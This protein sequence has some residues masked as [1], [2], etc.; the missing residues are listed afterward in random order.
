MFVIG[1]N[2]HRTV[3]SLSLDNWRWRI[4]DPYPNVNSIHSV[5]TVS[6]N[7]SFFAFGGV[8][9]SLVTNN[10]LRYINETWSRVGILMSKRMKY[11]VILNV[12]KVY[13]IG[14]QKKQKY[15]LCTLSNTVSCEQDSSIDMPGLEDP[16]LFG[17]KINGSC[18][19]T[20]LKFES[21]ETKELLILSKAK[22]NDV[23]N[24]VLV[25]NKNYR[26]NKHTF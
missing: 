4:L 18:E 22:F 7:R 20:V 16:A 1:G 5:K 2:A 23:D 19:L 10:I 21:R 26:N 6:H 9:E 13:V 3:E 17:I 15:D 12:D 14:G 11:S 8:N 24:F 25:Q